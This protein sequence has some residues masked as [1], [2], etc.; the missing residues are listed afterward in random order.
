M[1]VTVEAGTEQLG[2]NECGDPARLLP[3]IRNR[4]SPRAFSD[5]RISLKDLTTL[6]DAARSAPSSANEQ[7]WR[8]IVAPNPESPEYARL[9][10]VLNDSNQVW[11][12]HAPVLM[13]TVAKR[14]LTRTGAPNRHSMHDTG[15]ALAML[16]IQATS[17]GIYVHAMAGFNVEAAR[18][19][20]QIPHDFEPAAAVAIGYLGDPSMLSEQNRVREQTRSTR[21]P[22]EELFLFK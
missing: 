17:M 5:R 6:L 2:L 15:L 3:A 20:F 7:P 12:K 22:L 16:M 10:R 19:E 9:L 21:K 11:A 8:F 18:T 13:L 1:R 4:W 14:T